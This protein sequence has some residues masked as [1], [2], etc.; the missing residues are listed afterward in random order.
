MRN[1]K[2]CDI[3]LEGSVTGVTF[4]NIQGFDGKSEEE[5][6]YNLSMGVLV[7]SVSVCPHV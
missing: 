6:K 1:A 7:S 5:L 3:F 4:E 2:D